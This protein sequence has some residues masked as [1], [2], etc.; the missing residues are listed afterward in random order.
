MRGARI[1]GGGVGHAGSRG[2][3]CRVCHM[4]LGM[5]GAAWSNVARL[6]HGVAIHLG[7]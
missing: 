5:V 2:G 6:A 7:R 4:F 3:G 1:I